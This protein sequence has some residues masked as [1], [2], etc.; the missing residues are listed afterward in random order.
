MAKEQTVPYPFTH[1]A[2]VF[3]SLIFSARFAGISPGNVGKPRTSRTR[4]GGWALQIR[5]WS[6]STLTYFESR[7]TK[8]SQQPAKALLQ[9]FTCLSGF[10][11]GVRD[12]RCPAFSLP[13]RIT[14][15][16]IRATVSRL[17]R[18]LLLSI[19]L[20]ASASHF[21]V[22]PYAAWLDRFI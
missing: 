5:P 20:V 17:A 18:P 9:L 8:G 4:N 3:V 21:P 15:P 6:P 16:Q 2:T 14:K 1:L 12:H 19:A 11:L 22:N 13:S 7:R 10:V